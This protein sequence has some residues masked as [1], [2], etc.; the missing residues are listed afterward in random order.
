MFI[1]NNARFAMQDVI[2]FLRQLR[3]HNDRTWFEANKVR[4]TV[5]RNRNSPP[6]SRS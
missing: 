5:T 4:G 2:E 3:L 6:S 1:K